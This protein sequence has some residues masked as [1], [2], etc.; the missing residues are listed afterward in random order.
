MAELAHN[1]VLEGQE[2]AQT[3][4]KLG[5][6]TMYIPKRRAL[7]IKCEITVDQ[8]N[9]QT[10]LLDSGAMDNFIDYRTAERLGL[11][12]HKMPQSQRV[13]NVDGT[14]NQAGEITHYV[15]LYIQHNNR[16]EGSIF[17]VTNLGKDHMILGYPWLE[18]FNPDIDWENG[19]ILGTPITMKTPAA[20]TKE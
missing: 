11:Q 19:R 7:K 9:K 1:S 16:R 17:F 15:A 18:Q 10:M 8:S 2:F 14:E 12:K 3:I 20:V 13:L 5:I 6:E 4:R